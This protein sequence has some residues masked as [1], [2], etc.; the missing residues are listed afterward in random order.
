MRTYDSRVIRRTLIHKEKTK[1]GPQ[2]VVYKEFV[3]PLEFNHPFSED[4]LVTVVRK[5]DLKW[6]METL[7]DLKTDKE[8]LENQL[9]LLVI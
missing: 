6:L 7:R 4:E 8:N 5:N 1:N 3:V 9:E 2:D